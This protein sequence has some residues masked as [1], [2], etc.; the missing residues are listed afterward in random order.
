M[1]QSATFTAVDLSKLPPPAVIETLDF[2]AIYAQ[3]LASLQAFVPE[4]DATVESDPAVKLLQVFAYREMLLRARINDAARAVMP[5]FAIGADLDNLAALFGVT[6]LVVD[7]GDPGQLIAPTLESDGDLRRRMVLAPEGYSVAGP[8][9][10]YIF[11][12]LSADGEVLD[13]SAT[14]PVPGQVVVTILSREDEGEASPALLAT[15]AAHVSDESRRPLTDEVIVQGAAIVPFTIAAELTTFAGPDGGLVLEEALRRVNA[16][17]A[18]V[19]R[20]G[21]DV[22][23]SAIFAA[24]HAEGVQRVVLNQPATDIVISRLQAPW[25]TG[26]SV[27]HSGTGE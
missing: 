12:A 10:A 15:V 3:L 18:E 25:C 21:R 1:D 20:L 11:H 4:F 9:G 23:R 7:P 6:R 5:A 24:L 13:A 27:V 8:A 17:A 26:I 22:T 2:E 19:H 14:S 16:Y